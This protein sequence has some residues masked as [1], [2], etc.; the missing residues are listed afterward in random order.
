MT[1][2][3]QSRQVA[4]RDK[5]LQFA[6]AADRSVSY[7]CRHFGIS[8]KTFYKWKGR[9]DADGQAALG[10]RSRAPHRSPRSTPPEVVSNILYLRQRYHFGPGKIAGYLQ[11]FHAVTIAVASVHRVLQKHGMNRLPANQKHHRHHQRWQLRKTPTGASAP[12]GRQVPITD[13]GH[14]EAAVSVHRY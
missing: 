13:R 5:L 8:R 7:A 9:F 12:G 6:A 1:R 4:W 10:D 14:A 11:R 3:E 2:A